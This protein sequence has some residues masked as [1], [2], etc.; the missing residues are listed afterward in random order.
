MKYSQHFQTKETPQK[1]RIPGRSDQI[2]NSEG[3]YVWTV[4]DWKRLDR[5]LILGAEGGTYYIG[6]KRLTVE[7]AECVLRCLQ[8]DGLRTVA[9]IV[10][11]SEAGRAPKNGS[12]IFALAMA[13]S[14]GDDKT[15]NAALHAMPRVART[16]TDFFQFL[17]EVQEFRGWGRGLKNAAGRWYTEKDPAKLVYQLCKYRQRNGWTHRDVLRLTHPKSPTSAHNAL[18]RWVCT[19]N[20]NMGEREVARKEKGS[21]EETVSRYEAVDENTLPELIRYFSEVQHAE[22][23]KDVIRVIK[24]CKNISWEMIPTEFLKKPEVWEALLPYNL[25]QKALVRNLGRM[26]ANGLLQPL[27][28]AVRTV[29]SH[30]TNTDA[31]Q[32]SRLHPVSI[33]AALLTYRQGHGEKGKLSWSPV[34]QVIDALDRAFYLSFGNVVPTGKRLMLTLDLSGSMG[35]GEV[36]GISGLTPR[37]GAAA[38][39]LVTAATEPN[40][41]ITGFTA[42][43]D[44]TVRFPGKSNEG[45]DLG[46]SELPFSP[47]QRLDDV[48]S[49]AESHAR[50]RNFTGT[51]CSLPMQYALQRQIP[52][53]VFV[54]YTDSETWAGKIHPVQALNEYRRKMNI[55]ARLV[56]VG[57]VSNGFTIAD[58]RDSGMFDVVGFDTA[59]PQLISHFANGNV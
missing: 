15:R 49:L 2:E 44:N 22:S 43:G 47:R 33:L 18:F 52:V 24:S 26:T 55:S 40:H 58:P 37:M 28:D 46:I 30:I 13:A 39:A 50:S 4:D 29:V 34:A 41:M 21:S 42:V 23:E 35:G 5:F 27:S 36:A 10:E 57:M 9:R 12:A 3:G 20:G 7:N 48:V 59:A 38:M 8:N 14:M 56:V 45:L 16:G 51:D 1:E 32:H 19:E 31:I 11:I 6:E 53:D 54:V 17:E 25:P